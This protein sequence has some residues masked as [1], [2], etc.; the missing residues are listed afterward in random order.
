MSNVKV[1]KVDNLKLVIHL[2][3]K[4]NLKNVDYLKILQRD[5]SWI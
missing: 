3:V 1:V 2:Q 4:N 5:G